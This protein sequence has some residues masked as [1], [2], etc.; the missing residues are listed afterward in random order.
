MDDYVSKPLQPAELFE[1]VEQ[2]AA[3][4]DAPELAAVAATAVSATGSDHAVSRPISR[5]IPLP[6]DS[7]P[8]FD[9]AQA[10]HQSGGDAELL[11]ELLAEFLA[12]Y[13]PLVTEVREALAQGDVPRLKRAAHTLKGAAGAVGAS[14]VFDASERLGSMARNG[15]LAEAVPVCAELEETLDRLRQILLG[16]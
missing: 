3:E 16:E 15:D 7:S 12:E 8:D 6:P 13:P 1:T 4:P 10:L 9:R 5:V 14:T 2:V 11:K